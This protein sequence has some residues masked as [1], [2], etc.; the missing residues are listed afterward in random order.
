MRSGSPERNVVPVPVV[1]KP[2]PKQDRLLAV[3]RL[4]PCDKIGRELTQPPPHKTH[5]RPP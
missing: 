5:Q 1:E 4:S 2:G 3:Q